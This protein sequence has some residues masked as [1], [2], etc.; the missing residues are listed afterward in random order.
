VFLPTRQQGERP[1]NGS[2]VYKGDRPTVLAKGRRKN[3]R[4][5]RAQVAA[6]PRVLEGEKVMHCLIFS[7]PCFGFFA[8]AVKYSFSGFGFVARSL[9]RAWMPGPCGGA[10]P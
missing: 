3:S 1:K 5:P 7:L 10:G 8:C 6:R 2:V 9:N 4:F